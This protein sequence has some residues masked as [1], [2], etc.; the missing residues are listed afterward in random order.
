MLPASA[1]PAQRG[2]TDPHEDAELV[3]RVW[4]AMLTTQKLSWGGGF[5]GPHPGGPALVAHH[6]CRNPG[7]SQAG[8]VPADRS[9]QKEY[10]E[11]IF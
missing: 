3:G 10:F 6:R 11:V 8:P 9:R 5:T 1:E 4:Q 7:R 2:D